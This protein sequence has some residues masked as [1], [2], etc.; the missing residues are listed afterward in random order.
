VNLSKKGAMTI[1][2]LS[3]LFKRFDANKNKRVDTSELEE[4]LFNIG[5]NLNSD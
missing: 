3:R 1:R 4:G 5:I 2:A